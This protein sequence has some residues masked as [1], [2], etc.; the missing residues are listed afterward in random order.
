MDRVEAPRDDA[1]ARCQPMDGGRVGLGGLDDDRPGSGSGV[2]TSCGPPWRLNYLSDGL[3]AT[4][5]QA[6]AG[7]ALLMVVMPR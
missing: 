4:R 2:V 5:F 6:W 3:K 7:S 1:I